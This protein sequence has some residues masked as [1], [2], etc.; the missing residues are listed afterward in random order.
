MV[1][2]CDFCNEF[3]GKAANAFHTIYGGDLKSRILFQSEAFAVIP[4]LGQIV[5]GYLLVLPRRHSKAL[6]D[7]S[8]VD[9]N[10]LASISQWVGEILT[11]EY[12]PYVLFEH[13]TR[14]EGVGGCGIYHAHLHAVPLDTIS[15]RSDPVGVLKECFP[16]EKMANLREINERT[17]G[18]SCY[19]FYQDSEARG[20]LFN[21]GPL[22]SQYIRRLLAEATGEQVWNWRDVGRE[23][24]LL[25]TIERLSHHFDSPKQ[26]VEPNRLLTATP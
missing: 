23:E 3:S 4:S 19:L 18:L 9:I 2:A 11:R 16:Y 15:D 6:G 5:E 7:L 26:P 17:A 25:A 8:V 1:M 22:P 14:S 21:T 13:G 24:R 20:Y 12:G 10:E